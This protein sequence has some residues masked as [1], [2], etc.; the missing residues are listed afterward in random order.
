MT[1]GAEGRH[2][3]ITPE[4]EQLAPG[5]HVPESDPPRAPNVI[6][7]QPNDLRLPLP[8]V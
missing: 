6:P 7:A 5:G 8:P 3:R 2:V 4:G 1:V